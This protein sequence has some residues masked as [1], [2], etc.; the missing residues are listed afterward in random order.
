MMVELA[1]NSMIALQGSLSACRFGDCTE[2]S[3]DALG[4]PRPS[5]SIPPLDSVVL[6]LGPDAIAPVFKQIMSAGLKRAIVHIA[7]VRE[8]VLQF[9]ACD[10]FSADC[11]VVGPAI[12]P[13]TLD[14]LKRQG[15]I[16]SF[17]PCKEP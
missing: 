4:R 9:Q 14:E 13:T 2:S 8:G 10:N 6:D 1:G 11:V 16:H 17:V 7:I 12:S 3:A 5:T 15:L